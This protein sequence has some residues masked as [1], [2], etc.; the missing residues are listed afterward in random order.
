MSGAKYPIVELTPPSAKAIQAVGDLG[1]EL[2]KTIFGTGNRM[3]VLDE[4]K[5]LEAADTLRLKA[6]DGINK[7]EVRPEEEIEPGEDLKAAADAFFEEADNTGRPEAS[8]EVA[9]GAK[10]VSAEPGSLAYA[11]QSIELAPTMRA[12]KED[13]NKHY[14]RHG[15]RPSLSEGRLNTVH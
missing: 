2:Y 11:I 6:G 9:P 12:A 14:I 10:E 3:T 7:L 1:G 4:D 15:S 13:W 8:A 5:I